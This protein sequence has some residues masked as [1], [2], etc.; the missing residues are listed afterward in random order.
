VGFLEVYEELLTLSTVFPSVVLFIVVLNV[1][2]GGSLYFAPTFSN[3]LV[4]KVEEM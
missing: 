4:L 3:F 2:I 1:M